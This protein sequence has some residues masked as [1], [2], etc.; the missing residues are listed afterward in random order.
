[1]HAHVAL[2]AGFDLDERALRRACAQRLEDYMVPG[3]IFVHAE[4]PRNT[5]GKIDKLR[6]T[7]LSKAEVAQV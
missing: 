1:M 7:E 2:D 6:L 4:L 3:R 5:S